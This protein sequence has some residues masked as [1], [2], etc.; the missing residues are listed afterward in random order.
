MSDE[1]VEEVQGIYVNWDN[2]N[3]DEL[4]DIDITSDEELE[5]VEPNLEKHV[6]DDD[7]DDEV[8]DDDADDDMVNPLY[9]NS[10][11]DDTNDEMDE[12]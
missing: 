12:E 5:E 9:M 6:L 8:D 2:S 3:L 11:M 4:Y 1:D 7:I 10:E